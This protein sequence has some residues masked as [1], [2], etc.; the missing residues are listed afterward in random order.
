MDESLT[1]TF[2]DKNGEPI[3]AITKS[4]H[5]RKQL[6]KIMNDGP[7][8]LWFAYQMKTPERGEKLTLSEGSETLAEHTF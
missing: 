5:W 8:E 3:K 7:Q 4:D 2:F 6:L 1:I